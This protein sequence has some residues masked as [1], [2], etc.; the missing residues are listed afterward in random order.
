MSA[1]DEGPG[2]ILRLVRYEKR[3]MYM[4]IQCM[5]EWR[6]YGRYVQYGTFMLYRTYMLY[7]PNVPC[8]DGIYLTCSSL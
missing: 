5:Y 7:T 6:I 2:A 1:H 4:Y 3:Y 8:T